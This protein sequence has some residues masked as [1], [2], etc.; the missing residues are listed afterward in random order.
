MYGLSQD[1]WHPRHLME[2]ARGVGTPLQLDKATK[3]REFGYYARVLVDVDLANELPS[4]LMVKREAHCFPIEI[5]YENMCTYCG[6]VGHMADRCRQLQETQPSVSPTEINGTVP[7][8]TETCTVVALC[9]QGRDIDEERTI[10][11]N[12]RDI[13]AERTIKYN[14]RVSTPYDRASVPRICTLTSSENQFVTLAH[15]AIV[16]VANELIEQLADQ[17]FQGPNAQ[18]LDVENSMVVTNQALDDVDGSFPTPSTR[19]EDNATV[20]REPEDGMTVVLSRSQQ[21]KQKKMRENL[22]QE[23]AFDH[24]PARSRVPTSRLNL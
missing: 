8:R 5:V 14:R 16:G 4:S 9:D 23:K 12:G 20:V 2:I 18:T 21:K 17:V 7:S 22:L 1:Y 3:E 24:Y 13:D 10:E 15:E 19:T 6:M 11:D